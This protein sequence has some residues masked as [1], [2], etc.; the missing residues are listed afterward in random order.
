LPNAKGAVLVTD[1][2]TRMLSGPILATL[3]RLSVPNLLVIGAQAAVNIAETYYVGL[4]GTDSLAG[5]ALV[6][7][8]VMLMQMTSAGAMGGG[9]SS[10]IARALGAKRTAD[11][12]ALAWHAMLIALALGAGF[13][14]VALAFGPAIYEAMGG[15]G[16]AL[17]AA[18]VYSDWVFGGAILVWIMN[19]LASVLRGSGDMRTPAV[20][21]VWGAAVVIPLSPLLI[22]G[23]GNFAGYGLRGAAF[24]YL[25]YHASGSVILAWKILR[26]RT[27][28]TLRH[29]PARRAHFIDI[30]KVGLPACVHSIMINLAVAVTTGF[31][32]IYGTAALAGYGIGAR[33]EYL[34]IPIVFGFGGALVAMV[35]TNVGA[36]QTARARRIAWIGGGFAAAVCGGIGLLV[37]IAPHL[38][39]GWFSTDP[40]VL[41]VSAQYLH[42]AGPAYAFLGLGMALYFSFQ[43][44]GRMLWP[45][46][47]VG[48]RIGIIVIGCTVAGGILDL[49]LGSLFAVTAAALVVFG[50]MYVWVTTKYFAVR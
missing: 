4:L 45:L 23:L 15:K 38:W 33:L 28:V 35:G 24:A 3:L 9:I 31:V 1:A 27:A 2:R 40:E 20:V 17:E 41:A 50:A 42:I 11:A 14:I 46:A 12:Q 47:C 25:A 30:L 6:F 16:A 22:F 26:S 39:A 7:P 29:A 36:G 10:A 32:G 5:V 37:A 48:A 44:T 8:L 43:G 21:L 49:G 18:L 19:S 13:T 34:Q